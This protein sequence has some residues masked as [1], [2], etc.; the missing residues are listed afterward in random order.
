MTRI[1]NIGKGICISIIST[2][3]FLVLLELGFRI[4]GY[5][6][7]RSRMSPQESICVSEKEKGDHVILCVGDSFTFGRGAAREDT[8]PAQLQSIFRERDPDL[9]VRVINGASCEYNSSQVLSDLQEQIRRYKPDLIVLLVGS[10]NRFNFVGLYKQDKKNSAYTKIKDFV[11]GLGI[12]RAFKIVTLDL[13][14]KILKYRLTREEDK[15]LT[16]WLTDQKN[17]L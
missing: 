5:V 7:F 1:R 2:I 15:I 3:F 12:Y 10:A 17:L 16:D 13:R 11:Y 9:R 14:L 4:A 6:Y 8:Y